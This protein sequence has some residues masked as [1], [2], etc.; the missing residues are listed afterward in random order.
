MEYYINQSLRI[1]YAIYDNI[2][3]SMVISIV[4]LI[5]LIKFSKSGEDNNDKTG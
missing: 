1:I 2:S 4:V 5:L 3:I